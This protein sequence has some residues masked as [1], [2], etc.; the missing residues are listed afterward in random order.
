MAELL[1]SALIS[2]AIRRALVKKEMPTD[3]LPKH[4]G[5]S[6][7]YWQRRVSGE[8]PFSVDDL[9]ALCE[10]IDINVKN[11]FPKTGGN[12]PKPTERLCMFMSSVND[13][14]SLQEALPLGQE[15]FVL[16][17]ADYSSRDRWTLF[18][19]VMVL[20][21]YFQISDGLHWN[22]IFIAIND[23]VTDWAPGMEEKFVELSQEA[24]ELAEQDSTISFSS[25]STGK[26]NIIEVVF[27]ELYGYILHGDYERWQ[28]SLMT[29]ELPRMIA[30]ISW[31]SGVNNWL[32]RLF[33]FAIELG[34]S[35]GRISVE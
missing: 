15:A 2:I 31:V 18:T 5:E 9:V 6:Q 10:L 35:E 1:T 34:I 24:Q 30:V 3:E 32:F 25:P 23:V 20:R 33:S 28:R 27:D 7:D 22:K 13:Y 17:N 19:Y 4:L 14:K 26:R 21:K 11:L 12:P 16:G 8:T 29:P